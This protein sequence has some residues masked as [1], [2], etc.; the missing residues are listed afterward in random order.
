MFSYE[1]LI[2]PTCGSRFAA[3][4]D[5]VVCPECGLPHHRA[6]WKREGHCHMADKHGTPDQWN[7]KSDPVTN[8][9]VNEDD[10]EDDA[11]SL[12]ECPRCHAMNPEFAEYCTHCGAPLPQEDWHTKTEPPVH[13]FYSEY[14]PFFS[15]EPETSYDR[16]ERIDG[17]SA[18]DFAAVIGSNTDYYLA[19]FR[20]YAKDGKSGWNWAALI[21]GPYWLFYRKMY[22]AGTLVSLLHLF[23][24]AV[25]AFVLKFLNIQTIEDC[26]NAS[27]QVM[28]DPKASLCFTAMFIVSAVILII[29]IMLGGLGNRLY[30][31]H[32]TGVIRRARAD[33]PDLSAAELSGFG[34]SSMA[35]AV[36]SYFAL[37]FL[38]QLI[39][40][41]ITMIF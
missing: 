40:G 18:E 33:V 3:E 32:C 27:A 14:R 11:V 6:C 9:V 20:S 30:L 24:A 41:L 16:N 26:Y 8:T 15:S 2:C 21:F 36:I 37:S 19:H 4:D 12:N 1:G 34:G 38:T 17:V 7:R 29:R 22:L 23:Y 10:D 28:T 31:Q 13:R 39:S 35:I 25:S 5:V